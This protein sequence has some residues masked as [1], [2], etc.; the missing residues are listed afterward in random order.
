VGGPF[1]PDSITYT[2]TNAGGASLDWTASKGE[3]WVSLSATSGTLAAGASTTVTVSLNANANSLAA[4]GYSDAV[5]FADPS[6]PTTLHFRNVALDVIYLI[7]A[8]VEVGSAGQCQITLQGAPHQTYVIEASTNL[9]QW[10]AIE[11]NTSAADGK[12]IYLDTDAAQAS[13]R[14][15]RGR[16]R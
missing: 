2:L 9:A 11:T 8:S 16:S 10:S 12:L 3:T 14:F 6:V 15:Y 4:G 7:L 1:S 13:Q 5:V